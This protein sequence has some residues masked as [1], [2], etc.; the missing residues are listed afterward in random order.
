[1]T[2]RGKC[3]ICGR[4]RGSSEPERPF[5]AHFGPTLKIEDVWC[6]RCYPGRSA[7]VIECPECEGETRVECIQTSGGWPGQA[8]PKSWLEECPDCNGRGWQFIELEED[9]EG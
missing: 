9:D 8:G 7:D 5:T 4:M 3:P 2:W 6:P 1:M